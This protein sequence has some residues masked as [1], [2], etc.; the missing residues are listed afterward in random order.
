MVSSHDGGDDRLN[1]LLVD[2]GVR[3]L[4][5]E[6]VVER[7]DVVLT[8]RQGSVDNLVL[9]DPFVDIPSV[10]RGP[11]SHGDRDA[12]AGRSHGSLIRA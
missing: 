5:R 9:N 6:H 3:L 10:F 7:K 4:L 1:D 11:N 12:V 8:I 2:I